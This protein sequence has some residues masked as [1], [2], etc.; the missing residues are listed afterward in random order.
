MIAGRIGAVDDPGTKQFKRGAPNVRA[1][2]ARLVGVGIVAGDTNAL[3]NGA[4][5]R[6]ELGL[7]VRGRAG[8]RLLGLGGDGGWI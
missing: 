4:P 8:V 5:A 6:D 2:R 3:I 7:T 1:Q